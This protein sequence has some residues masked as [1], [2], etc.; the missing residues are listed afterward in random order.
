[1]KEDFW[2]KA[3]DQQLK[4]A[5]KHFLSLVEISKHFAIVAYNLLIHNNFNNYMADSESSS[6]AAI[7]IAILMAKQMQEKKKQKDMG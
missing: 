4:N 5:T 2:Q 6:A 3:E 7:I 1:M